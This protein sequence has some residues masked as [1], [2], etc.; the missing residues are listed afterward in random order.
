M[1]ASRDARATRVAVFQGW[2]GD[3]RRLKDGDIRT[4]GA[5]CRR[6]QDSW[7]GGFCQRWRQVWIAGAAKRDGR[8]VELA[9][10]CR[11]PELRR[12]T[13]RGLTSV[14]L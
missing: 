3:G 8:P 9:R 7:R 1:V 13:P 4:A 10:L 2:G 12:F 14:W 11:C 6:H 5:A